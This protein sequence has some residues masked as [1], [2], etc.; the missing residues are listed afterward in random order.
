[1]V[2]LRSGYNDVQVTKL[3]LSED[4]MQ[5]LT[6]SSFFLLKRSVTRKITALFGE[7]EREM[8]RRFPEFE[9]Q[10][11]GLNHSSG[12][13]F[14]GENYRLFPYILLDYPR[15]FSTEG[16]FAFRTMFWWGHEFSY[17]LHLQ[18]KAFEEYGERIFEGLETLKG[19]ESY[20]CISKTPWQYNFVNENYREIDKGVSREEFFDKNFCEAKQKNSGRGN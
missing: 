9:I 3:N 7:M 2:Y 15:Q 1:M 14:R 10:Y 8:K 4:E 13:I 19:T 6:N 20:Y 5:V 17:T 18:G 11:D 16:V 12:K